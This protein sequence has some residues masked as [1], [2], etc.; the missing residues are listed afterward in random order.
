MEA[1]LGGLAITLKLHH[2]G[3]DRKEPVTGPVSWGGWFT[4]VTSFNML[5]L[6]EK[7]GGP[8]GCG[9][10]GNVSLS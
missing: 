3:T 2:F 8:A 5:S 6:T 4:W 10:R 9:V 1:T 7:T